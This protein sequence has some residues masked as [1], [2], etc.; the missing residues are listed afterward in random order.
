MTILGKGVGVLAKGIG[1]GSPSYVL[2][3]TPDEPI[4]H[5]F[6]VSF[7]YENGV[8]KAYVRAG[9][10]NNIVPTINDEPLDSDVKGVLT[11]TEDGSINHIVLEASIGDPPVFL[12]DTVTVQTKAPNNHDDTDENGYLVLASYIAQD[13]RFITTS[14][15]VYASQVLVRAKPGTET[16]IWFWSSR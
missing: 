5:P 6:R 14:Q 11:L 8:P 7:F 9:T 16:A 15:F 13:G 12:P 10:V 2:Q 4:I 1:S 3:D